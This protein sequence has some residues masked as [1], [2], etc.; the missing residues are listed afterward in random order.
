[1]S[2]NKVTCMKSPYSD[3]RKAKAIATLSVYNMKAAGSKE[4]G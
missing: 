1:M 3:E 2:Y 4:G